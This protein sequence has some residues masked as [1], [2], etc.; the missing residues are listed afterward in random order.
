MV[1]SGPA[2]TSGARE[3]AYH[4]ADL[5]G[6][7]QGRHVDKATRR[8]YLVHLQQPQEE[9]RWLVQTYMR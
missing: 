2:S 7:R 9:Q 5:A 3:K 8:P 6:S 1:W 4:G